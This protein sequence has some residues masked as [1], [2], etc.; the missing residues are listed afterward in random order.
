MDSLHAFSGIIIYNFAHVIIPRVFDY[1]IICGRLGT[2]NSHMVLLP[3]GA[4][5]LEG[6]T[7]KCRGHGP[8]FFRPV[9]AP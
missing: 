8:L 7:G 6:S 9:G 3:L 2:F 1:R 5:A 4:P